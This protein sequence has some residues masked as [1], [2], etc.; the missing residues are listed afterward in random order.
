MSNSIRLLFVCKLPTVLCMAAGLCFLVTAQQAPQ[1][2][3]PKSAIRVD[4]NVVSVGI[5][6]T[7][8]GGKFVNGLEAKDFRVFDNGV[9]QVLTSFYSSGE[10]GQ[11]VLVMECGPAA[12]FMKNS[13][14]LAA[15]RLLQALSPKDRIAIITYSRDPRVLLDFT[16]DKAT[17]IAALHSMNFMAGFSELDLASSMAKILN[18]LSTVPGKKSVVL[19]S[20]G[21]DTSSEADW[22]SLQQQIAASDVRIFAASIASDIR[23]PEKRKHPSSNEREDRAFFESNF[24]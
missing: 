8:A 9:E 24:C 7:S 15:D 14:L 11:I 18:G 17:A 2:V 20:S 5:T 6:V 19:L 22:A 21:V 12:I 1:S 16:S 13:G 10:P 3:T 23:K 4:V